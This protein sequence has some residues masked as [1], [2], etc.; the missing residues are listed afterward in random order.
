[1]PVFNISK[2]ASFPRVAQRCMA[3]IIPLLLC[4]ASHLLKS[5]ALLHRTN[6]LPPVSRVLQSQPK[7]EFNI[8]DCQIT[9]YHSL[10][11]HVPSH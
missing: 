4:Q 5:L 7:N 11:G 10:P 9:P 6:S 1:M 2:R 8:S 3:Q